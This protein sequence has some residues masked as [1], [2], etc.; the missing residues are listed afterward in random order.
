MS[1]IRITIERPEFTPAQTQQI[2]EASV[3]RIHCRFTKAFQIFEA[4]LKEQ[5]DEIHRVWV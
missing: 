5:T 3:A 1:T 2:N 4:L